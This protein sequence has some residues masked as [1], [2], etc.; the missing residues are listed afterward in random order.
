MNKTWQFRCKNMG[1]NQMCNPMLIR[2]E[3]NLLFISVVINR[4]KCIGANNGPDMCT[5]VVKS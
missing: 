3:T 1:V 2:R 5:I 4:L